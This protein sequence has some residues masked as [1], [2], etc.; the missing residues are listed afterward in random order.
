MEGNL[1]G[2]G[3]L[4]QGPEQ[5]ALSTAG[6]EVGSHSSQHTSITTTSPVFLGRHHL[7]FK[8]FSKLFLSQPVTPIARMADKLCPM[9][10][11]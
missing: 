3:H 1:G 10:Q 5:R 8:P 7:V 9:F 4:C 11:L 6:C 2:I